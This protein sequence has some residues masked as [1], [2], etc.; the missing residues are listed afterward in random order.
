VI[1]AQISGW[2]RR[3]LPGLD[4]RAAGEPAGH[5]TSTCLAR[6]TK[7]EMKLALSPGAI[8]QMRAIGERT[9]MQVP[10]ERVACFADPS[11]GEQLVAS[12]ISA[13]DVYPG[14]SQQGLPDL[15]AV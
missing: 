5:A 12:V 14:E 1:I 15:F 6:D 8:R 11:A 3:A 13:G 4:S 10:H 7:N 2:S 9:G